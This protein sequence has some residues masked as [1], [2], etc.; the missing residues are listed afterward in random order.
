MEKCIWKILV[1]TLIH[2]SYKKCTL[3]VILVSTQTSKWDL[4]PLGNSIMGDYRF[5]YIYWNINIWELYMYG[6]YIYIFQYIPENV[7]FYQFLNIRIYYEAQK[8]KILE[9]LNDTESLLMN[10][11][12][13]YEQS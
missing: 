9:V 10:Q 13:S 11:H 5:G 1:V 2:L 7:A 3:N 6:K 12:T 4:F 8:N